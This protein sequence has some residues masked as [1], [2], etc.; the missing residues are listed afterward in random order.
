MSDTPDEPARDEAHETTR[1]E[2]P[3][4]PDEEPRPWYR[5][6]RFLLP[7]VAVLAFLFGIGVG[8]EDEPS[9]DP[10]ADVES[11]REE[12]AEVESE[13]DELE[14]ELAEVEDERDR[15]EEELAE[16]EDERE[17]REAQAAEDSERVEQLE[18]R[19]AGLEQQVSQLEDERETL[20][21]R[22]SQRAQRIEQLE[23]ELASAQQSQP[24]PQPQ[25]EQPSQAGAHYDNCSEARAAGAAPLRRGEPGY[26]DALDGDND[27]VAC[28]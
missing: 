3:S 22:N 1:L 12:V 20:Q 26:R 2:R 24:A 9:M 14:D 21:A 5:K 13:R 4:G 11:L 28:E 18:E 16:L 27:G 10:A 19:V 25:Q 23:A 8:D 7:I 6:K 15:L 17:S